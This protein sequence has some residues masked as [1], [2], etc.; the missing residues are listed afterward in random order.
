[1]EIRRT[2]AQDLERV[3][4]IFDLARDFMRRSGNMSQWGGGYPSE[5]LILSDIR[6]GVSYVVT[7]EGAVVGTFVFVIGADPTYSEID[8]GWLNDEPYGTIHR[9]ASDGSRRGIADECLKFCKALINN[10]RIDTHKDNTVML[11]WINRSGFKRCGIIRIADGTPREAFQL[12]N[13]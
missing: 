11:N 3:M 10:I 12:T 13:N 6:K 7:D 8:G 2:I 5:D 4:R 1:M 9:I